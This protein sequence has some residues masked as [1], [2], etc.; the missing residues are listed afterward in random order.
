MASILLAGLTSRKTLRLYFIAQL[1]C[2]LALFLF[3][4][5]GAYTFVYL[6]ADLLMLELCG[7]LLVEARANRA[8]FRTAA[9]FGA[10]VTSIASFGIPTMSTDAWIVLV[11][12]GVFSALG[13]AMM[14]CGETI[15]MLGIGTLTMAMSVYDFGWVRNDSWRN[16]N[17]WVP[18][19]LCTITF[20]F[21]ALW[22]SSPRWVRRREDT[23]FPS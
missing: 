3:A 23:A 17:G 16:A 1:C 20:L 18:S 19:L 8:T 2:T 7:F 14:L 15:P 21:I 10:I 13:I 22:N 9:T 12:G 6:A 5:S 4:G 11:E